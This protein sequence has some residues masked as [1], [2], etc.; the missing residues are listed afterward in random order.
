M[1]PAAGGQGGRG[2]HHGACREGHW[3]PSRPPRSGAEKLGQPAR[4][5]GGCRGVGV[6]ALS[7]L[8][9]LLRGPDHLP[10]PRPSRPWSPL[11]EEGTSDSASR[12]RTPTP[13]PSRHQQASAPARLV[14]LRVTTESEGKPARG[15]ARASSP[16]CFPGGL[17]GKSVLTQLE[18]SAAPAA[19]ASSLT[20]NAPRPRRL[21]RP[22]PGEPRV[23]FPPADRCCP[24][25]LAPFGGRVSGFRALRSVSPGNRCRAS[26]LCG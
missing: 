21:E 26:A 1:T 7:S 19:R 22:P 10:E 2:P 8:A 16:T 12:P 3:G 13:T 4:G 20:S 18:C 23:T 14:A 5:S 15:A 17:V 25:P 11:G 6:T 9:G 24:Q